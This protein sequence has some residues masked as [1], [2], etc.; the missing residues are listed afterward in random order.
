[1]RF[2]VVVC[3]QGFLDFSRGRGRKVFQITL[4]I[5]GFSHRSYLIIIGSDFHSINQTLCLCCLLLG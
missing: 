4:Q 3:E 1:M 2:M 5:E